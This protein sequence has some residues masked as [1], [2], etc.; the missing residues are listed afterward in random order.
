MPF[1]VTLFF[2]IIYC[3]IAKPRETVRNPFGLF[4]WDD[5]SALLADRKRF[6]SPYAI[7]SIDLRSMNVS[8]WPKVEQVKSIPVISMSAFLTAKSSLV[9]VAS[10][11]IICI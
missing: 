11:W 6:A 8:R 5:A 4:Y 9:I 3:I 2:L 1:C 10:T 7:V